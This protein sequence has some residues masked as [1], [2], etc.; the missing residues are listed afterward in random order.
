M[1]TAGKAFVLAGVVITGLA[2][3][4]LAPVLVPFLVGAALAYMGDPLVDRLERH[5]SRTQA[6][7]LVFS[8]LTLAVFAL[9]LVVVPLL[10][11]QVAVLMRRLPDYLER[12]QQH[13]L[14]WLATRLGIELPALDTGTLAAY[15]REHWSE[16]GGLVSMALGGVSRTGLALLAW[17]GNLLLIPVVTFYLLRDWDLLMGRLH[18]LVP[19]RVEPVAVQLA[20]AADQVLGAFFRGQFMVMLALGMVYSAGLALVGLELALLIGLV[21]GLVSFVPYLGFAVGIVAAGIAAVMQ[22]GEILPLLGVLAVFTVGQLLEGFVLTP[23]LLGDRIGL[24]PLAVIF[25]VLAGGQLFGFVGILIALPVAAVAMVML[26]YAH[27]Q[28]LASALYG[29]PPP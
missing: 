4:L 24:H 12:L 26:R 7:V 29:N 20:R 23:W 15:V 25:A 22:F 13:V 16:A 27:E 8:V 6:V 18:E 10:A 17:V 14:P 5:F 21:A 28:Y 19:R 1:S 2:I 11:E 3:Y 9:A